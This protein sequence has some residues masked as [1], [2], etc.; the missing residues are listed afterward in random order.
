LSIL[1]LILFIQVEV[2]MT[3]QTTFFRGDQNQVCLK[4]DEGYFLEGVT[5]QA[6]NFA[7]NGGFQRFVV[8]QRELNSSC[9]CMIDAVHLSPY[10]NTVLDP[11]YYV[12]FKLVSL[13]RRLPWIGEGIVEKAQDLMGCSQLRQNNDWTK[14]VIM[15]S[16][17]CLG[18]NEKQGLP[19]NNLRDYVTLLERTL[20]GKKDESLPK[21][22]QRDL[23]QGDVVIEIE[24][25]SRELIGV[26]EL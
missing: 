11:V 9:Y 13:I 16:V 7:K 10:W 24:E 1:L 22:N 5:S 6:V 18:A 19:S 25:I 17:K 26:N 2:K 23:L 3:A 15:L 12:A 8:I 21:I 4:F 14:Y 20:H